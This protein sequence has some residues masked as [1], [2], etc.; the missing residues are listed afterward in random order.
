MERVI[1]QQIDKKQSFYSSAL[2][3]F[4]ISPRSKFVVRIHMV[5]R[6]LVREEMTLPLLARVSPRPVVIR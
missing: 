5:S 3:R 4:Y 6:P 2:A 1:S